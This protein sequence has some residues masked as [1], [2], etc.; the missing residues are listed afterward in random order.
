M[1]AAIENA[2]QKID[3]MPR[4]FVSNYTNAA[5]GEAIT[6]CQAVDDIMSEVNE[7]LNTL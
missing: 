1:V 2:M 6:A 7:L 4:P 3:A 5:C